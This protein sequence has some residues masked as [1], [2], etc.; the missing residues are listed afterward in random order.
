MQISAQDQKPG[1]CHIMRPLHPTICELENLAIHAELMS[2]VSYSS[3]I[4]L[5]E[6]FPSHTL[7]DSTMSFIGRLLTKYTWKLSWAHPSTAPEVGAFPC[8]PFGMLQQSCTISP[9]QSKWNNR[10]RTSMRTCVFHIQKSCYYLHTSIASSETKP[11]LSL[12]NQ[13]CFLCCQWHWW[14]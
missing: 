6:V 13:D 1:T 5:N 8:F 4:Y 2:N 3:Q 12:Y 10:R 11:H 14:S 7:G 9:L